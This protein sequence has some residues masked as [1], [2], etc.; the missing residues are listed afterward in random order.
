MDELAWLEGFLGKRLRESLPPTPAPDST[1][2]FIFLNLQSDS[3]SVLAELSLRPL[4]LQPILQ[5]PI[6]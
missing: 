1:F 3:T 2:Y 4:S 6:N 5:A